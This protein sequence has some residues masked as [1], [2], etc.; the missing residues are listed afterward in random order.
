VRAEDVE[1]TAERTAAKG[2]EAGCRQNRLEE[3]FPLGRIPIRYCGS[4]LFDPL[5]FLNVSIKSG[6]KC[7]QQSALVVLFEVHKAE[8]LMIR[9]KRRQHFCCRK[10]QSLVR[11]EHQRSNGIL[12]HGPGQGQH[13][14]GSRD[15][16]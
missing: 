5:L 7:G 6:L 4:E 3:I 12:I 2:C 9:G 15:C 13:P 8:W 1:D 10:D 11:P 16:M 14:A